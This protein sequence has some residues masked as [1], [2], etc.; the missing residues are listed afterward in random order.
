MSSAM[1][2]YS[3]LLGCVDHKVHSRFMIIE[4]PSALRGQVAI[5]TRRKLRFL[6]L[7]C[8]LSQ[9]TLRDGDGMVSF[10]IR[11]GPTHQQTVVILRDRWVGVSRNS[12]KICVL[13]EQ[14]EREKSF[15]IVDWHLEYRVFSL[16]TVSPLLIPF[17]I[18]QSTCR[19]IYCWPVWW[20]LIALRPTA[21]RPSR[22]GGRGPFLP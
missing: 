16:G 5:C 22:C 8:W 17:S 6:T 19:L 12:P 14:D 1:L 2:A 4:K 18:M 20:G 11:G 13:V 15:P 7:V 10:E 21:T 9:T 3:G